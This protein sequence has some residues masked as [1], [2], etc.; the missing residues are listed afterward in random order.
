M[1]FIHRQYDAQA[2]ELAVRAGR[3]VV[4]GPHREQRVDRPGP[5]HQ[6]GRR[7]GGQRRRARSPTT[8]GPSTSPTTPRR[9]TRCAQRWERQ[10][11]GRAAGHRRVAVPGADR[12]RSSPTSTSSTRPGRRTRR[13]R[14][15]SSSCPST[16]PGTGGS[17]SSTTSRPSGCESALLGR[18]HTVV[19]DVPY[20]REDTDR[21]GR[22]AAER[23]AGTRRP[24]AQRTDGRSA[25]S[26]GGIVTAVPDSR[27]HRSFRR[28]VVALNGGPSDA[29]DRPARAAEQARAHQGRA[30][31][32]PRRRDRLDAA[33][34]C[35]HRRRLRGGPAG[36]RHGRGG[37]RGVEGR[38]SSRCCSRRATSARRSS[39]RRSSAAPTCSSSACPT[40]SG[41]V[42]TSPSAGPS[43][44]SSRTRRARSGSCAS[45]S[46]R[47]QREDRHR[48][49]RP[50]RRRPLA[51]TSTRAGHEVDHPRHARPRPSTACRR[52]SAGSAI[53]GD[54]TDEDVLR[55]AGAE[56]ADVFLALTEGDN[57]N[58]MAAQLATEA[59]GVG[60]VDRQD[61][62][63]GPGGGLRRARHRHALPDRPDG[64]R[65]Q[66]ATSG[67]PPS[68]LPGMLAADRAAI[69]AA[70]APR[71]R[72]AGAAAVGAGD[73][74]RPARHRDQE[75]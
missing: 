25:H 27:S 20:R 64:R 1:L 7:P 52:R 69:P 36:P 13:R 50:R 51:E 29:T 32:R 5:G 8:S 47:R 60:R 10:L 19:V 61:Q 12:R 42:A 3:L 22:A 68:G 2:R 55:R 46:P 70:R 26:R 66:R 75:A 72:R 67:L 41:S 34:R 9:P 11:P 39:T 44:T 35:R 65:D 40:A 14:S 58:V 43:R 31:R 17:G 48:R 45:R 49:L 71:G 21:R 23:S 74:R 16:S 62:R 6:P 30:G 56:G 59:L 18:P 4:A 24:R 37:R 54:G 38:R 28:A 33:A 15:R 73:R 57:R 53:R 63:P